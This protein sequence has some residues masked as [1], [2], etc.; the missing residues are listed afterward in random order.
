MEDITQN[1]GNIS[2]IDAVTDAVIAF[3]SLYGLRVLGALAV[4]GIGFWL[5]NIVVRIMRKALTRARI[6]PTLLGFMVNVI[7][8]ILLA[9]IIIISLGQLGV[10]TTSLAAIIAAAGL[11]IGLSLQ[12]SLS[13]LAS[14]VMIIFF[15]PFRADQFVEVAGVTGIVESISIF[16][17]TLKTPD[18]K[19]VIV[20]NG[21]ITDNII[22]NFTARDTRRMELPVSVGYGEN[23]LHVKEILM[24]IL[25]ED[26]GV[27]KDPEPQVGVWE[28]ASSSVN[29]VVRPWV[30]T[31]EYWDVFFRLQEKIKLT[32]DKEGIEIPFPQRVVHTIPAK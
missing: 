12:N 22:T 7:N 17:T 2:D 8:V 21:K 24:N 5:K 26:E 11:A 25:R 28:F 23:V 15:K 30:K 31:A 4:F 18:N 16:T 3:L 9:L 29:F 13:N 1:L 14:G 10:E 19:V 6:E 27:L 32:L 20:P